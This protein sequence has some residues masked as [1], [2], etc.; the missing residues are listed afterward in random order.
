MAHMLISPPPGI[1]FNLITFTLGLLEAIETTIK[2]TPK[3]MQELLNSN[4]NK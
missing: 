1:L 2:S 4:K 3:T